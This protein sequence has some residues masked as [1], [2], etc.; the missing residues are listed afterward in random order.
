VLC[1]RSF[2]KAPSH[3]QA[4]SRRACAVSMCVGVW[5]CVCVLCVCVLCVRSCR[6]APSHP[7]ADSCRVF[8]CIGANTCIVHICFLVH[9]LSA[10]NSE[11]V[12]SIGADL[13]NYTHNHTRVH[14]KHSMVCLPSYIRTHACVLVLQTCFSLLGSEH[15]PDI[16]RWLPINIRTRVFCRRRTGPIYIRTH[17]YV[18]GFHKY[19]RYILGW[20]YVPCIALTSVSTY[21]HTY[22]RIRIRIYVLLYKDNIYI[23][24]HIYV[25][26]HTF[27]SWQ[28]GYAFYR[29]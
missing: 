17:T 24:T 10:L 3:L 11:D 12:H 29:R 22:T 4:D 14:T 26:T 1:V 21:L 7:Q 25:Y 19:D 28:G 18:Y 16:S 9:S 5:V 27:C 15:M 20:E 13:P 23:Y 2:R 8:T 6:K